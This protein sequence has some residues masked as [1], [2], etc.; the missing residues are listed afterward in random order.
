[1]A[2]KLHN[3]CI[4]DESSLSTDLL[5]AD[6]SGEHET[7]AEPRAQRLDHRS[8]AQ[9]ID[10]DIAQGSPHVGNVGNPRTERPDRGRAGTSKK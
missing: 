2:M 7:E 4:S 5:D 10:P 9:Q 1:M 3:L 6:V 8:R